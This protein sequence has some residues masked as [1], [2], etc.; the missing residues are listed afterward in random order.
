MM[1][2]NPASV[3]YLRRMALLFLGYACAVILASLLI[4]EGA[5]ASPQFIALS[6]FPGL[7]VIGWIW[8]MGRYLIDLDDEYLRMLEVRKLFVATALT[9]AVSSVW[10]L[11]E[12]FIAVPKLPVFYIFPI[13][14]LGLGV[15]GL[16]NRFTLGDDGN[17]A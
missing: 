6:L 7:F 4:P 3:Q 14:C 1:N 13:W 11:F 10:G 2:A 5:A 16:V 9:M 17:C 8:A 15:G 12:F